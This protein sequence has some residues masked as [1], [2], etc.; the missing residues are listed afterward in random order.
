MEVY[1][2]HNRERKDRLES[3]INECQTQGI[4]DVT[5][6]PAIFADKPQT[7][8]AI[9]HANCVLDAK[10]KGLEQVCIMEDDVQFTAPEAFNHFLNLYNS[11]PK[12]ADIFLSGISTGTPTKHSNGIARV[13]EFS[14]LHCYII[15]AKAY[16][17]FLSCPRGKHIDRW[18]GNR[19]SGGKMNVFTAYP[20][21]AIQHNGYS[22]N[23]KQVKD[24]SHLF[25]KH[26][27]W[28]KTKK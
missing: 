20:M 5:F 15:N 28:P 19:I 27:L 16:D 4:K 7:G 10:N 21:V 13:N 25:N 9:A 8:I 3:F 23:K 6:F 26:P 18:L 17:R 1:V 2:I 24:Y 11:V 12:E 22:D 14:G